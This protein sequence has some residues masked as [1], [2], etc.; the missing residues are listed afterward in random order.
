[1]VARVKPSTS[2]LVCASQRSGTTLLCRAL[3]DTGVA[4]RPD[5]YFLAVDERDHPEWRGWEHGPFGRAHQARDREHYL[6][7]VSDLGSTPN[8]VFGAKLM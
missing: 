1:L 4:G 5:E 8:G 7:I 3:A 2:Y 6:D